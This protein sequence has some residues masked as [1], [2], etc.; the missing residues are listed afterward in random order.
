MC[1]EGYEGR[2]IDYRVRWMERKKDGCPHLQL[3]RE[4]RLRGLTTSCVAGEV[5]VETREV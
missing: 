1:R 5:G 3:E 2:R 4:I